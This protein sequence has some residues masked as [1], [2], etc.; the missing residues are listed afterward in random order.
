MGGLGGA[1]RK[2]VI[3]TVV[4]AMFAGVA[5]VSTVTVG[6]GTAAAAGTLSCDVLYSVDNNTSNAQQ[7]DPATGKATPAFELKPSGSNHNQ[8]GIG[9]GGAYA[10]YTSGDKIY[11]YDA[12][13][14]TTSN[15]V[16]KPSGFSTTHGAVNPADGLYYFGG[17]TDHGF[18]FGVY[19]PKANEAT[20]AVIN[21][22][23]DKKPGDNGDLAF[24]AKGNMYIVAAS[25]SKGVV[26]SVPGPMPTS[27]K[28]QLEGTAVTQVTDAF[29]A[30]NSIAFGPNG[31]LF[32]GSSDHLYRVDPSSG[33]RVE[34]LVNSGMTDM[35]SCV[36]PNTIEVH[37]NLPDGRVGKDDQFG[38]EITGDGL[39]TGNTATTS[40]DKSG[41]Q[42]VGAGPV[43]GLAGN[44]YTI[45]ETA[46]NGAD[47]SN[48]TVSWECVDAK[49]QEKASGSGASTTVTIPA[50]RSGKSVSCTFTNAAKKPGLALEKSV[51]PDAAYKVGDVVTYSFKMTNTGAVPLTDVK[52]A[53][54][55]FTGTLGKMSAF[56]CPDAGKPLAPNASTTCTATYEIQQGDVDRGT[57][58]NTAT[59]TGTDP[60]G[61]PVNSNE[62]S[63]K[64]VGNPAA[65]GIAIEKTAEPREN[66]Q[67]GDT[68]TYKFAITNTGDQT[69]TEVKVKE[70]EFSG[71]GTL[72]DIT[73]PDNSLDPGESVTCEA[74][75]T[76]TDGDMKAGSIDN[77][78]TA[79][80]TPPSKAP[81]ESNPS[82][83][84]VTAG[85]QPGGTGSL[86]SL[87]LGS[88]GSLGAG[89]LGSGSLAAGS[90]A[91][92]SL[93][94]GSLA[95]G[96]LENSGSQENAGSAGSSG[97]AG[98]QENSGSAGSGS[99][100]RGTPGGNPGTPGGN[101]GTPAN[102][103]T[104]GDPGTP[105]NAGN[106]GNGNAGN[107][108]A[109]G[110]SDTEKGALID[111]G[112]G[113]DG[114][115]GLN[116]G[117][118]AGGLAL[119]VAAAGVLFM[120]LRRRRAAEGDVT[121]L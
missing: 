95:A 61:K 80:G 37:K 34:E 8:L 115:G 24:D 35:G 60:G 70:N 68:V 38:L 31:Y 107:G 119:L 7:I 5:T 28:T 45:K 16:D 65:P 63:A 23:V 56:N 47:L 59:A 44:T 82:D 121:D 96:S 40:G 102:P 100:N 75:Y 22:K 88:L 77:V 52:P 42:D 41:L 108:G 103:G 51:S 48:Y 21:V 74:T 58:L 114:D 30:S 97:S 85:E 18:K 90:L 43:L 81:I 86:G 4:M 106:S 49:T 99:G 69:L 3:R 109:A 110:N 15:G 93:A 17:A 62:S 46:K 53:E 67:V 76:F 50:G 10:I 87:G 14:G 55:S 116:T 13:S 36:D 72:S 1:L 66:V 39:S 78:A 29:N 84:T 71:T 111:S 117:L 19:N 11:K 92:G 112:L 33:K 2:G 73:C 104:P 25:D 101:P 79:T 6:A 83:A 54:K 20:N 105:G 89:S 120:A 9:A 98:S 27:G 26:Y 32:V 113:A 118:V 91:A 12:A 57:V 64:T 94:A